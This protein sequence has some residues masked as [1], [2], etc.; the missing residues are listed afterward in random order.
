M[1]SP[2]R[3][4]YFILAALSLLTFNAW[5]QGPPA[6]AVHVSTV[7]SETIEEYQKVTGSLRAVSRAGVAALEE[8]QV[9]EVTVQESDPIKKGAILARLDDRRLRAQL[10]EK[11]ASLAVSEATVVERKAE[12]ARTQQDFDRARNLWET[13]VTT[14][15]DFDHAKADL[16]V[17][18]AMVNASEKRIHQI[19]SEIDLLKVRLEDL[20]VEAPF[21]GIVVERHVEPGEWI[22]LGS[23][24]ATLVST[25]GIEAWI[26]VPERYAKFLTD[27]K[28]SVDLEI[29]ATGERV[30]ANKTEAIPDVHFRTRNFMLVAKIENPDGALA[31]GMSVSAWI[32]TSEKSEQ[33]TVPKDAVIRDSV[34]AFIYRAVEKGDGGH[35]A[36]RTPVQVLFESGDRMAVRSAS[37]KAGD[38]VV[39]EGNERLLP[40]TIVSLIDKDEPSLAQASSPIESEAQSR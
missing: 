21:D 34:S 14:E 39:I 40:G 36:V 25:G 22:E 30:T 32:P 26:E 12:L 17:A 18:E 1:T 4:V 24:V 9:V 7:E 8:G 28:R 31:P 37:L 6:T 13:S 33:L 27:V 19:E 11:E 35:E 16:A 29:H 20:T 38:P 15:K 10:E 5:A 2:D 23:Q 3:P